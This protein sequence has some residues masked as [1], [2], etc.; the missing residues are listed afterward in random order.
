MG[1]DSAVTFVDDGAAHT[2]AAQNTYERNNIE[3][4][5]AVIV[6]LDK[7]AGSGRWRMSVS[8]TSLTFYTFA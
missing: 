4:V 8:V 1:V 7:F 3:I 6:I 5:C 2:T